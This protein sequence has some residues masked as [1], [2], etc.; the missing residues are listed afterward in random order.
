VRPLII[1]TSFLLFSFGANAKTVLD[2]VFTAAQA[3]RGQ[4]VYTVNCARCHEGAD[5][6]GP[7]L[8]GDPFIDRWREDKLSSL[9]AFIHT[10][11]PQ[12]APGKLTDA[13]Y[14]DVVAHLLDA[15][16]Y[17]AGTNELTLDALNDTLL[18]GKAGPKPLPSNAIIRVSGCLTAVNGDSWTLSNAS[19]AARSRQTEQTPDDLKEGNARLLGFATYRLQNL[20]EVQPA[21]DAAANK[22]HKVLVKGVLVHQSNGDRINVTAVSS[23]APACMP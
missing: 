8:T 12:N 2:G 13:Q 6:D 7:P 16:G 23:L 5:V 14:L 19:D 15:N 9:F 1:F 11:M 3:S 20:D 22:G 4:G 21:F 18:V 10:K 17:T